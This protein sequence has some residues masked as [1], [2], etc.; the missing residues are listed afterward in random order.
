MTWKQHSIKQVLKR[1]KPGNWRATQYYT[2][3][4]MAHFWGRKPSELG[5]CEEADDPAV[6]MSYYLATKGIE[7]YD[8]HPQNKEIEK[9]NRKAKR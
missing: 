2:E 7:A 1:I 3:I 9:A 4:G 8:M 6:M 5:L